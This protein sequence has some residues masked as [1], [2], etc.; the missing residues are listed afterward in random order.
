MKTIIAL[1]VLVGASATGFAQ[2]PDKYFDAVATAALSRVEARE[3]GI[4]TYVVAT[5]VDPR[6]RDALAK[7]RKVVP[8]EAVPLSSEVS[9]PSGYF[10]VEKFQVSENE[11]LFEG[12]AGPIYRNNPLSCG[13]GLSIPFQRVNGKWV[14]PVQRET[15]C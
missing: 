11:A 6:A 2:P 9:L 5:S 4:T 1:W 3:K 12:T 10:R 13:H 7:L 8:T 15:M 14:A